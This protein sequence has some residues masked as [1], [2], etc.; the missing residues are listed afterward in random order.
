MSIFPADDPNTADMEGHGLKVTLRRDRGNRSS[1]HLRLDE[2]AELARGTHTSEDGDIVVE[3]APVDLKVLSHPAVV[4]DMH[5]TKLSDDDSAWT[6]GRAGMLYRDLI[7]SRLGGAVTAAHIRIPTGGS[8][9]DNV[10]FHT[11]SFQLIYCVKGWVRVLY[12]AQGD[13]FVLHAGDCVTQPPGIRHR[14]L[15][16]SDMLEVLEVG[17]PSVHYTSFDWGLSLP[18]K[19]EGGR[20]WGKPPQ[21]FCRF[22]RDGAVFVESGGGG[23]FGICDTGVAE[24]SNGVASVRVHLMQQVSQAPA[25][26]TENTH[27]I[28]LL[29]GRVGYAVVTIQAD[30]VDQSEGVEEV[31]LRPGGSVTIRKGDWYQLKGF[32]EGTEVVEVVL[33]YLYTQEE[34]EE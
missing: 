34:E 24:H 6:I 8:V 25:V 27:N 3:V 15:E 30:K 11:V 29:Y 28:L 26:F 17:S 13:S 21:R 33:P 7:P 14:V 20:V 4:P 9:A 16:S 5:I 1:T 23:G 12:E 22:E 19:V 32:E 2:S 18:T 31:H 10:H